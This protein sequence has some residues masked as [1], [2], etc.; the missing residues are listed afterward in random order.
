MEF[1]NSMKMDSSVLYCLSSH[2]IVYNFSTGHVKTFN[3]GSSTSHLIDQY[4]LQINLNAIK[5]KGLTQKSSSVK[6]L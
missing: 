2:R 1:E 3:I 5:N 4:Y 6:V